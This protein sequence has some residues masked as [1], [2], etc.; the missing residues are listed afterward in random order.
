M[1]AHIQKNI[2]KVK[3][4]ERG[5]TQI[6]IWKD[7]TQPPPHKTRSKQ[8]QLQ[9]ICSYCPCKQQ[10]KRYLGIH[11]TS[12]LPP[13]IRKMNHEKDEQ[14]AKWNNTDKQQQKHSA[15]ILKRTYPALP[16]TPPVSPST[17]KKETPSN[18]W[19]AVAHTGNI[20]RAEEILTGQYLTLYQKTV[21]RMKENKSRS[22]PRMYIQKLYTPFPAKSHSKT[23]IHCSM[24][25]CTCRDGKGRRGDLSHVWTATSRSGPTASAE[26]EARKKR[27][28]KLA[29]LH[30]FFF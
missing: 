2:H 8:K 14:S 20:G 1:F 15:W 30:T 27:M 13:F 9:L 16:P 19:A 21:H 22:K 4:K 25:Y 7:D 17:S 24:G 18:Y 26:N 3:H 11:Q 6:Y 10:G 12:G 28:Q 23:S 5:I 29:K